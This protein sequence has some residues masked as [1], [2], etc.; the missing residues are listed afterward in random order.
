[1]TRETEQ[2]LVPV[3]PTPEMVK[4]GVKCAQNSHAGF[5]R[6]GYRAMLAAAPPVPSPDTGKMGGEERR[7]ADAE[8]SKLGKGMAEDL[9]AGHWSVTD[10]VQII[11]ALS[12]RLASLSRAPVSGGEGEAVAWRFR[13]KH[14]DGP[15]FTSLSPWSY[16]DEKPEWANIYPPERRE[17]Q[18]LYTHPSDPDATERMQQAVLLAA[19]TFDRYADLHRAKETPDGLSKAETNAALARQ[20]RSALRGNDGR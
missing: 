13:P 7:L 5:M 11:D 8:L 3:E 10:A 12:D 4:A 15:E 6:E 1:M 16:S 2:K 20:M 9:K 17:L 14:P 18:P 19:D